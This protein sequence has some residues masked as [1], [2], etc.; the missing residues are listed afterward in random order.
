LKQNREQAVRDGVLEL[1]LWH[2][3]GNGDQFMNTFQEEIT[4]GVEE[5][6]GEIP[7]SV[8]VAGSRGNPLTVTYDIPIREHDDFFKAYVAALDEAFFDIVIQNR[9]LI[10]LITESFESSLEV[11]E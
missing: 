1:E 5:S 4:R 2:G 11:F 7:A 6:D 10:T 8:S 3:T 9:E